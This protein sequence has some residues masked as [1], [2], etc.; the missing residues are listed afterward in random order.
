M[1]VVKQCG[2]SPQA[3][4]GRESGKGNKAMTGTT[5]VEFESWMKQVDAII[6][7]RTSLSYLDLPDFCYRD[8]FESGTSPAAAASAAIRAARDEAD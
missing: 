4:A 2:T 7:R 1:N 6:S 8:E 5:T 3:C